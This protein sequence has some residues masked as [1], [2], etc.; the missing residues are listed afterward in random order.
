MPAA[1]PSL[2]MNSAVTGPV[3]GGAPE[4]MA[5][6]AAAVLPCLAALAWEEARR[7]HVIAALA[8]FG[9]AAVAGGFYR[10]GDSPDHLS[11]LGHAERYF[12]LYYLMF[13][14]GLIVCLPSK[15]RW[16]RIAAGALLLLMLRAS[17]TEQKGS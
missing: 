9:L 7:F 12:Y 15:A 16:R 8:Y 5:I 14:W 6:G 11:R 3:A 17:L 2:S 10:E 1:Q 13:A 4:A